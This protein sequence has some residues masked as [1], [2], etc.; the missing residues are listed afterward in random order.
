MLTCTTEI[1]YYKG[2]KET[3]TLNE[4]AAEVCP[5]KAKS[6]SS[7][8]YSTQRTKLNSCLTGQILL[9]FMEPEGSFTMLTRAHHM[10]LF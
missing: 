9:P 7:P 10:E 2:N 8:T 3:K 4:N 5:F 6:S 1:L